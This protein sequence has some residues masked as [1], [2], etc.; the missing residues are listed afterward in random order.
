MAISPFDPVD[1]DRSNAELEKAKQLLADAKARVNPDIAKQVSSIYKQA[2]YVPASV[3]LAMAK[4]G[5]SQAALDAIKPAAI[6]QAAADLD[7]Q[8]PKKESWFERTV[9]DK[10]KGVSRWTFASL[11]VV[12]DLVQNA[13]AEAF[14]PNDPRGMDGFFK[15]TQ[16]G[17]MLADSQD[18]GDGFFI[19]GAAAKNQAQRARETRGTINGHAWTIGRGAASVAFTPGSV[20]Y[21]VMSGFLDAAVAIGTDPTNY[22]GPQIAAARKAKAALPGL[23]TDAERA[24]ARL[25]ASGEAGLESAEAAAFNQS[26]FGTFVTQDRRAQRVVNKLVGISAD[27]SASIEKRT[28]QILEE[29]NYNISPEIAREF[30]KADS[31]DKVYG[32]LGD[33]S[34]KLA[35]SPDNVLL[36]KDVRDFR[37]AGATSKL[38]DDVAERSP[39]FRSMRNSK[40][41]TSMPKNTVVVNGTGLDRSKAVQNYSNYLVGVGIE[42]GSQQFDEAM[43]VVTKAYSITGA[44]EGRAAVQDAFDKVFEIALTKAGGNK[45]LAQKVVSEARQRLADARA[46][47]VDEIG[48]ADDGGFIQ[49]IREMV[50]EEVFSKFPPDTWDRLVLQGPG[51]LVELADEVHVLPDFRQMRTLMSNPFV[52]KA[53]AN[54]EGEQR[55]AFVITEFVQNEV[56]KPLALA[57]GGY[58]MRN[59]IDA[60]T[61]IAMSGLS[62]AF[63][64]PQDFLLWALNKK[65]YADIRGVDF[66]I[67]VANTAS[68]WNVEQEEFRE[69]LTFNTYKNLEDTALAKEK[70]LRNGNFSLVNRGVDADAH[71]TGYVDNLGQLNADPINQRLSQLRLEGL[72]DATRRKRI[73]EWLLSEEGAPEANRLREYF[74]IGIRYTEPISGDVGYIKLGDDIADDVLVEWVDKLSNFKV[75]T[76]VRDDNELRIVAGYNKVPLTRVDKTG[77]TVAVAP[78]RMTEDELLP[79]D[80]LTGAD[81]PGNLLNLG[82]DTEGLIL[83][84]RTIDTGE[85]DPFTG[86]PVEPKVQYVVQP[87]FKG[88]AFEGSLGSKALRDLIDAKGSEGKLAQVVKRA[89]RGIPEDPK[90]ADKALKAK[91]RLVDFFFANLYGKATQKLEKSPV[92]RQYYYGE[93]FD[94]LDELSPEAARQLI[95][96]LT[97]IVSK[98]GLSID[99]YVGRKNA[100]DSLNKAASRAAAEAGTG[101]VEQLDQY[102]KAVAVRQTKELLYNATERNNLEDILR[103][104]VPFGPAWKEVLGTY[105]DFLVEDPSR[106]RRA[107]LIFDGA[108]K[109]DPDGD[110]EGFFYKDPTT[111]EYSFNFPFSGA[112]SKLLTGGA[113][114]APLQAPVK[115][116]SIGLGVIPSIGPVAQLAASKLIPDTPSTD[117]ITSILLPYG[118]VSNLSIT[119]RWA[120]RLKEVVEAN[121]TNL[122]TV[123]GNTYIETLRALSTTGE[124]D[125][126]D[127]NEQ[128]RLYADARNKARIIAGMRALGTFFGPTSPS[129]EFKIDTIQGDI[130]GTQLVKE[131][132]KLQDPNLTG[133]DGR[134]GNYDTA[135][136]RF[137][138]IFGNDALLYLSN[139]TESV[140]G[141][142]EATEQFSDWQRNNKDLL[143]KYPEVAGFMAPGGDDFSFEAWSRQVRQ[144]LRRRLSDR[145]IVAAAQFKIA[146]S[147]YNALRDKL[148]AKPSKEQKTWLR[149]WRVELN[150]QYP[151]FPVVAEF[152]PAEFPNKIEKMRLMVQESSLAD[153]EPAQALA[154]Y[155]E[156]RD[157]ALASAAAGGYNS[158]QSDAAAPLRDWLSDI[159]RALK[160][161]TP[162]FSRIYD[163][164][165]K[166]EVEE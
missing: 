151:A 35:N 131:F 107:Q 81:T 7:P 127:P 4:S 154:Q 166:Y 10:V 79:R 38:F 63:R 123:Y 161:E 48:W 26:K 25:L 49:A 145:E 70:M 6:K 136:Q 133:A 89:E 164:L 138:E 86:K 132:Q 20:A 122:Q 104:I 102:A 42:K 100:L 19:G 27:T 147:Q 85:I 137:L 12:P 96:N 52:R 115:R 93:V 114:E 66:D 65:G 72:N 24:A 88:G 67:E 41:W 126:S 3:I 22:L 84:R 59:M 119:P 124:Y 155:L 68:R 51:A 98:E 110:G 128:E 17:S 75:N 159:G 31:V 74:K 21:N 55:G 9:W 39:L 163:R 13:A 46:F 57:T 146:S 30:A 36:P 60:Q 134:P 2:P 61:R 153:N 87:V 45:Q 94:N 47:N 23:T 157:K 37:A 34:S 77:K 135:V 5:T 106:I 95:T 97:E 11:N 149:N 91:N 144:G 1:E 109:L 150:K 108:R 64:H 156:A 139:K 56:W 58:I 62:G 142:L 103:V 92:F 50:G 148:P 129:P 80:L 113:V 165:L 28:R 99:K 14:S 32:L 78:Y 8:K 121:Q 90:L 16:L 158:L 130:Y 160:D 54:K 44:G 40:W 141:G 18:T 117:F 143:K 83:A 140:A 125:L 76:I 116:L 29:F 43:D 69:A 112:I 120:T 33:A 162:E 71:T 73:K 152:N 101:T 82:D 15:S 53:L 118:R 111:G 105:A